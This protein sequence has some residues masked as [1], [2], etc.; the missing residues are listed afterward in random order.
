M[1]ERENFVGAFARWRHCIEA[2][3]ATLANNN[4]GYIEDD[5]D[6]DLW[7]GIMSRGSVAEFLTSATRDERAE[8]Q[9]LDE[10]F[11]TLLPRV[12]TKFN[13]WHW[14]A[15]QSTDAGEW[16]WHVGK[17]SFGQIV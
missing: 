3:R 10:D 2:L 11:R 14:Y 17:E 7:H 9:K 12:L 15:Q 6:A 4:E 13:A 5:V 1:N 8:L 16:W